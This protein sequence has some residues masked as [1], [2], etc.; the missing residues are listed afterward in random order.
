MSLLDL[1]KKNSVAG[2]FKNYSYKMNAFDLSQAHT[3]ESFGI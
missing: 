2:T 3:K 1:V